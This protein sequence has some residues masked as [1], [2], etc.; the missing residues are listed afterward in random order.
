MERSL[1]WNN[2][3]NVT[4]DQVIFLQSKGQIVTGLLMVGLRGEKIV[5]SILDLKKH[6]S[7][8]RAAQPLFDGGT[9]QRTHRYIYKRL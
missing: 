2:K 6:G 9:R 8:N 3:G 7:K 5:G 1:A 4:V